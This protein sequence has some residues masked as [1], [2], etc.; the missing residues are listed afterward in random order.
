MPNPPRRNAKRG[1]YWLAERPDSPYWYITWYDRNSRQTRGRST[2]ETDY[3]EA[4]I[5]LHEHALARQRPRKAEPETVYMSV[6]ITEYLQEHAVNLASYEQAKIAGEYLIGSETASGFFEGGDTVGDLTPKRQKEFIGWL[7]AK[8]HSANYIA[9]TLAVLRAALNRTYR[10]GELKSVPY[11]E[12]PAIDN[13]RERILTMEEMA[14][15]F[16]AATSDHL[17]MFLM[18]SANT[19]AR[20]EAVLDLTRFQA[21]FGHRL[22]NLNPQGRKQT[23][24]YRP[25]VPITAT[26]LPWLRAVKSGHFVSYRGRRIKNIRKAFAESGRSAGIEGRIYPYVL[27][28][29]MATELRKR[30]VPPWELSGILGHRGEGSRTTEVYAKYA[31]D[32]L[33]LA[34]KAIDAYF[35]E[36]SAL[37]KRPL[38]TSCVPV[39]KIKGPE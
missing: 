9:R 6:V 25:V 19:L 35:A 39:E 7:A 32:Y 12:S 5:R 17:L 36:L 38:R 18:I 31:P 8:G 20:P 23:K 29:T 34:V 37:T 4:A 27:R 3:D 1:D 24:K 14:A 30:G 11:I 26:L 28:H 10:A 33:G 16:D 21:D 2:G 22:L 15:L 13:P